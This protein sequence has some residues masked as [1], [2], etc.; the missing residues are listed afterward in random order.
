MKITNKQLRQI[1]KEELEAVI[2]ESEESIEGQVVHA[3]GMQIW[4]DMGAAFADRDSAFVQAEAQVQ[5]MIA[6]G[7]DLQQEL[8]N[9]KAAVPPITK[10]RPY[11]RSWHGD[12]GQDNLPH[13]STWDE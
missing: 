10:T 7:V 12:D 3:L 1:I 6:G 8:A 4:D 11:K 5:Q 2:S 9:L 13:Q